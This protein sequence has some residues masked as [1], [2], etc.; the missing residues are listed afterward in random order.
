M[1]VIKG[2]HLGPFD[3][4]PP[5]PG[6]CKECAVKHEPEQPHNKQSLFYQ[7]NFY[8]QHVQPTWSLADVGRCFSSLF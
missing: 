5:P 1:E 3:L 7:Y 8:N 2:K 6:T 4:M